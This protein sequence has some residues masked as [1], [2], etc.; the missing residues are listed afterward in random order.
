MKQNTTIAIIAA[1][2]VAVLAGVIGYFVLGSGKPE[3]AANQATVPPL[4]ADARSFGPWALTCAN[5]DKAVKRCAM[6]IRVLDQQSKRMMLAINVTRGPRGNPILV[7]VTPPSV[8]TS[9]G[10]TVA[11]ATGAAVKAPVQSCTPQ[12]CMA[13]FLIDEA[14]QKSLTNSPTTT[15][16]YVAGNGRA[17]SYPL[18]T[19][20]FGDG[21]AA[22]EKDYPRPPAAAGQK[23]ATAAAKPAAAPKP[24]PAAT[25]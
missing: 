15:F 8:T 21:F 17:I 1:A 16:Q 3:Q 11:P 19:R 23:P 5:D 25:P 12:R 10:L 24:A 22:F 13:I 9:Q 4:P 6:V 14:L 2:V 20:G 18:P 7:V